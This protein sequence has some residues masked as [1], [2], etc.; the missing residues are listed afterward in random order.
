MAFFSFLT[1]INT[2]KNII[3]SSRA[4]IGLFFLMAGMVPAV[5]E[6]IW[7]DYLIHLHGSGHAYLV[8]PLTDT[9]VADLETGQGGT[10]GSTTPD[11]SK[12]YVGAAASGEN[13]VTVIDLKKRVVTA[14]VETGSRPKHP[15][16]SPDG[17]WVGINHWGLDNGQLRVSFIDTATDTVAKE[18]ALNV[19]EPEATKVASMH[20]AWSLDSRWFYTLDRIDNQLIVIDSHNWSV[21]E[22]EVASPPH[23]PVPSPN[24]Q[25]LW[26]ILEGNETNTPK[27]VVYDLTKA[28]MPMIAQLEMPLVGEEVVEGHHGNFTQDGRYFMMCSRGPGDNLK[29]RAVAIFDTQTK[30]L[31]RRLTTASTG[32]GHTYNTPNGRYAVV[33]N[34]GNNVISIIDIAQKTVIK[35]LAI[36]TGRMGHIAFTQEGH[37]GY[38]SNSLDGSLY[39]LD[40]E[41]L[42]VIK[43]IATNGSPGAGQVLN[44]WTNVFEELPRSLFTEATISQDGFLHIPRIRY[45]T[46]L[47]EMLLWANFTLVP[48]DDNRMLFEMVDFGVLS[49]KAEFAGEATLSAELALHIPMVRRET[50]YWADLQPVPSADDKLRFKVVGAGEL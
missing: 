28:D 7:P 24:G 47:G 1:N 49:D 18:I 37:Y 50:L 38:I 14:R 46:L 43:E 8:D 17:Q 23:Y 11:G 26:L 2:M 19:A 20:N 35:D 45:K 22:I 3:H 6:V 31:V 10:L 16:V 29:G 33:T 48:T 12:V 5:A 44:V 13:I 30:V 36:G 40:M 34:Y 41:K 39:K 27:T 21:T 15:L 42:E 9:V 32:I 25:E 4:L